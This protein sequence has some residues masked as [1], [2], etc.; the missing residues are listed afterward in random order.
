[1]QLPCSLAIKMFMVLWFGIYNTLATYSGLRYTYMYLDQSNGMR[2]TKAYIFGKIILKVHSVN[3]TIAIVSTCTLQ[4]IFLSY[5]R[6]LKCICWCLLQNGIH[7]ISAPMCASVMVMPWRWLLDW[8][9]TSLVSVPLTI[10]LRSFKFSE[11]YKHFWWQKIDLIT[12]K[13][14]TYQ[15]SYAVLVCAKFRFDQTN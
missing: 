10:C 2:F 11:N 9:L 7:F 3:V 12:M 13:F 14:C 15:D 6:I 4:I 8:L 5:L 1:M